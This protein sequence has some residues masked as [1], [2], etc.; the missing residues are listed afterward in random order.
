MK[1]RVRVGSGSSIRREVSLRVERAAEIWSGG[2]GLVVE[3]AVEYVTPSWVGSEVVSWR[4]ERVRVR[5]KKKK[6]EGMVFS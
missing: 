5:V 3:A 1:V 6:R 4:R 2:G